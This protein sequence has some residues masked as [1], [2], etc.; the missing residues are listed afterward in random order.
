[1][2]KAIASA[3]AVTVSATGLVRAYRLG[4][5]PTGSLLGATWAVVT[6]GLRNEAAFH[7]AAGSAEV[8][9]FAAEA[10]V[11]AAVVAGS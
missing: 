3:K 4:V 10:A 2:A 6:A 9:D 11:E 7:M 5:A 8:V 1:M